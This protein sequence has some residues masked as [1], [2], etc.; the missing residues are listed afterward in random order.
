MNGFQG[1]SRRPTT[2]YSRR[3]LEADV[4]DLLVRQR[5]C[6]LRLLG[7]FLYG[8]S[9]RSRAIGCL[10]RRGFG[11]LLAAGPVQVFA[12]IE[13]TLVAAVV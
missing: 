7:G 3:F 13:D 9:S 5:R 1:V 2:K 4:F 12:D 10:C 11:E 6:K 8:L